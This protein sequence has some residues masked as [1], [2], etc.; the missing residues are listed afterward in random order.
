MTISSDQGPV[1]NGLALGLSLQEIIEPMAAGGVTACNWTVA[2]PGI[3]TPNDLAGVIRT[4]AGVRRALKAN[5]SSGRL[6]TTAEDIRRCSQDG[7]PGIILGFQDPAAIEQTPDLIDLFHALGVRVIQI[8]YQR[9]G[10]FGSGSGESSD[11]GL[12]DFGRQCISRMNE[13]GI[14][15]DLSHVGP[16]TTLDAIDASV[17][18]CA[19][20]HTAVNTITPHPR[21]KTDEAIQRL[22]ARGGVVGVIG[23]SAYLRPDGNAGTTVDDIVR[24]ISYLLDLVGVDHV[25]IGLDIVE[26]MTEDFWDK[27]VM[28]SFAELPGLETADP[29]RFE[30]YYPAGLRSMRNMGLIAEALGGQGLA[31]ADVQKVMGGNFLRLF[32]EVWAA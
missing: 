18:P 12:S 9:Q 26:G 20:T 25:G 4:I 10:S 21:T 15:V 8:A 16:R 24:Q 29:F 1:I 11:G 27:R 19:F 3:L 31:D 13:L 30:T 22:A 2:A 7:V 23:V 17:H 14:L 6:V 32:E 28:P 5:E